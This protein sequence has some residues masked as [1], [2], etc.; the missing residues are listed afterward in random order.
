MSFCILEIW[1][2]GLS[3]AEKLRKKF[4]TKDVEDVEKFNQDR[5]LPWNSEKNYKQQSF[6]IKIS[7]LC[8]K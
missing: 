4:K 1:V 5:F 8:V 2:G 6:L 3:G 7:I